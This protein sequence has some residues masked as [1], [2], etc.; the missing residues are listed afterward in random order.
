MVVVSGSFYFGKR[1]V[2]R[3]HGKQIQ[4]LITSANLDTPDAAR[5]QAKNLVAGIAGTHKLKPAESRKLE[6]IYAEGL[7]QWMHTWTEARLKGLSTEESRPLQSQRWNE[8]QR[9]AN[10]YL[11]SVTAG[12][13]K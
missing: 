9:K 6:D 12:R 5:R 2:D 1:M 10:E 13:S 3:Y 8:C 4:A 11:A 7:Y